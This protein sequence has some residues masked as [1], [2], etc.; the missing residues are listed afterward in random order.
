MNIIKQLDS[1]LSAVNFEQALKYTRFRRY[2]KENI[3]EHLT[4]MFGT[5]QGVKNPD[6][7]YKVQRIFIPLDIKIDDNIIELST[8]TTRPEIFISRWTYDILRDF[9]TYYNDSLTEE[10]QK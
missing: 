7:T 10:E 2:L 4:N 1:L 3:D 8:E 6:K 9:V 5:K